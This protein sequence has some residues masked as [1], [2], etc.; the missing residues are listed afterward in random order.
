[1]HGLKIYTS[2]YM[3]ILA[4]QLARTVREPLSSPLSPEIIVV[5]SR[6]MERWVSLE[7]ARHNGICANCH[8]P[9]PNVFLEEFFKKM[10]GDLPDESPFDP[11][12]VK[13]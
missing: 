8:F 6:G 11:G 9:F 3:E 4:E 5:Q 13:T 12:Q 2:N 10:I 7:L 1:M